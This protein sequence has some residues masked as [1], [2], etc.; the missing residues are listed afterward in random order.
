QSHGQSSDAAE[1]PTVL[2]AAA[3][4]PRAERAPVPFVLPGE[5]LSK[6]GGERVPETE[7][8]EPPAPPRP[9]SSFKPATMVEAPLAWDGSGLLPG[10]SLSRH[11][12][13]EP[14]PEASAGMHGEPQGV[15]ADAAHGS[16]VEEDFA[17]ESVEYLPAAGGEAVSEPSPGAAI[18]TT[19]V[20]PEEQLNTEELVMEEQ[21]E[22][23][24]PG[25]PVE[26]LPPEVTIPEPVVADPFASD[27]FFAGQA[28]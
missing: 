9:A 6:Y 10:E 19:D 7:K 28:S 1:T 8:T 23:P 13:R 3:P 11:R 24:L 20:E 14:E 12:R 15:F 2:A 17:E 25:A 22:E 16:P 5:S 21:P 27:P 26:T 4:S 18:E